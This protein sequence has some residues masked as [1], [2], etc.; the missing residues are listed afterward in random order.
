MEWQQIL[1]AGISA[2]AIIAAAAIPAA[3]NARRA[4]EHAEAMVEQV[5]PTNGTKLHEYVERT[6]QR[7]EELIRLVLEARDLGVRADAKLDAHVADV[8]P[9]KNAFIDHIQRPDAHG[10]S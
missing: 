6:D 9:L 3:I 8:E 4:R 1:I 10:K 5:V 2:T 7:L